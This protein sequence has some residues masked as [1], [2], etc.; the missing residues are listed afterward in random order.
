MPLILPR[1]F[2]KDWLKPINTKVDQDLLVTLIQSY[3]E[4]ELEAFTVPRLR[5]KEAIGNVPAAVKPFRYQELEQE[6]GSL[7]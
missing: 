2:E 5:G 3:D 7:F 4:R 1:Q 6:Q